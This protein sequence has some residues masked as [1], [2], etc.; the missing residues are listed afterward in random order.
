MS[1][2]VERIRVGLVAGSLLLLMVLA[3]TYGFARYRAAKAWLIRGKKLL[4]SSVARETDGYTFSHTLGPNTSFTLHAAKTFQH[5]NGLWTLHDV[6]IEVYEAHENRVDRIYGNQFEWDENQGIARAVGEVQM[7]LQLPSSV[8]ATQRHGSPATAGGAENVHVRTSGLVFVRKLGV[9]ATT[10]QIEFSYKG[11]TCVAK[12]AEFDNSP[13]A[14]HLLA[15]VQINGVMHEQP[16]VLHAVKVDLDRDSNVVSF[17]QPLLE[18]ADRKARA[19]SAV[20]HL[21]RDGSVERAEATGGVALDSATTHVTAPRLDATMDAKNNPQT[22]KL[23]GGVKLVDDD[24]KRPS[25]GEAGE[26]R[27]RF[28]ALGHPQEMTAVNGAHLLAKQAGAG[29]V[30]LE[31]EM[32]GDQIV[33]ELHSEGKKGKPQLQS[34]HATGA[35][36]MRGDSLAKAVGTQLRGMKV[37]SVAADDLLANFV[38]DGPKKVRIDKLHGQGHTMLRQ[39]APL[40]EEHTSTGDTLDVLFAGDGAASAQTDLRQVSVASATQVGH[41]AISNRAAVKPGSKKAQDVST[42]TAEQAVYDGASEKLSLRGGVHLVDAGT[43]VAADSVVVDQKTEDALAQGNVAAT[44]AGSGSAEPTHVT[45]QQAT[46]HKATQLAVFEGSAAKQARLWQDASQ[47]EAATIIVDRQNKT[48]VAR[49]ATA[50]GTLHSVFAAEPKPGAA[51]KLGASK[52]PSILRV[53][54]RLLEYSDAQHDAV[55]TGLVKMDGSIGEVRGQKTTI[56][57]IPATKDSSKSNN[58]EMGAMGGSLDHVVVSGGVTLDEPG[59][60]GTGDQLVYK[61]ADG[62]F[63]LTGTP[64]VMPKIVDAQQGTVTGASLLFRA[65]DKGD[66]TIVV[67]GAPAGEEK[68]QR[69]R[70][71]TRVRQKAE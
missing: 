42:G 38:S 31:R 41:V 64:S 27:L 44:L 40:A 52:T 25:Q 1:R 23:S 17:V 2:R 36:S 8:V 62:S 6:V 43:A 16:V 50:G 14:L 49:P 21:R 9:A 71:E 13:S 26:V 66:S 24:G 28:D 33:A 18:T 61:A 39:A 57:F 20:L 70:I 67:T 54:S 45:A 48:L 55:F 47:V 3:G 58:G 4:R 30:W 32:R 46:L 53:E 35:A 37:T 22:A 56:Y 11:L 19:D 63:V 7:D 69:V 59:K 5:D 15:D 60:H 51:P 10:E 12:G 65:G 68:P 34:I 29:G